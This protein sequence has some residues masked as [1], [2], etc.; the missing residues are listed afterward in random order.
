MGLIRHVATIGGASLP[1]GSNI[2]DLEVGIFGGNVV[3]YAGSFADGGIMRFQLAPG[4]T[5]S[6]MQSAARSG[7]TGTLGLSDLALVQ[8]GGGWHLLG[9]GRYSDSPA[10]RSLS[11]T[12]GR[13]GGVTRL[14]AP[15]GDLSRLS[16]ATGVSVEDRSFLALGSWNKPGLQLFELSSGPALSL[17]AALPDTAKANLG[18]VSDL[19]SVRIGSR[20]FLVAASA[21]DSGVTVFEIAGG[22]IRMTDAI[23]A[24]DGLGMAGTSALASAVVDGVTY[25]IAAATGSG[26]LTVLRLN[27]HGVLFP[28]FHAVDSLATRF[29]GVADVATFAFNKRSFLLAGG[30]DD[31]LTL[32]EIGP[33]GVLY[34]MEVIPQQ[35]GWTLEGVQAIAVAVLGSTAQIFVTGS[36]QPGI[37]QLQ[38]D[39]SRFAPPLL[40]GAAANT[41]VGGPQDDHIEGRGGDDRLEG[42]AGNDRLVDGTGSDTLVGGAG[43]DVFVFVRDGARDVIQDF[44]KGIDRI[45]LTAWPML[46]DVSQLSIVQTATGARISF[47]A[48]TIDIVSATG[49]GISPALFGPDDFFFS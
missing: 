26:T 24:I 39:L 41:L 4:A 27:E 44:E 46:Y 17:I 40:G 37:T 28:V 34:L 32:F 25:V 11:A 48:E 14:S 42:G 12:D 22:S 38:L 35:P 43:A 5:A 36:G 21:K 49:K 16:A 33:G 8:L 18:D 13:I 47:G 9:A 23:G 1:H 3:L 20:T 6:L 31:G 45:D 7:G 19:L 15:Q 2:V 29:A 10:L 30:S